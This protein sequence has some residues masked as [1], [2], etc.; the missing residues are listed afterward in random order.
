MS[1]GDPKIDEEF[2]GNLHIFWSTVFSFKSVNCKSKILNN[3]DQKVLRRGLRDIRI[4]ICKLQEAEAD[5]AM[6]LD[7]RNE[8]GRGALS[9]GKKNKKKKTKS[10]R[11][12]K[13]AV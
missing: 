5:M 11:Q 13:L 12:M 3:L 9:K 10:S 8:Q 7:V 1:K 4:L 6:Y 2:K